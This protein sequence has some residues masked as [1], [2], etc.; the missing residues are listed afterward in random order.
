ML[1][2]LKKTFVD[3]NKK[4]LKKYHKSVVKINELEPQMQALG[5]ADFPHKTAEFKK[6]IQ[7]GTESIRHS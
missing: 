1:E 6:R 2:K 5:N 4:I 3:P 7:D